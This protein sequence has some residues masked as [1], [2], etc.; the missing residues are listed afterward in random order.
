[1][2][3]TIVRTTFESVWGLPKRLNTTPENNKESQMFGRLQKGVILF[4][5]GPGR[6]RG[7]AYLVG[8][9]GPPWLGDPQRS[10]CFWQS[11]IATRGLDQSDSNNYLVLFAFTAKS[12]VL[13][14]RGESK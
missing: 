14:K 2:F 4:S 7:K 5:R 12:Q 10:T 9:P 8:R 3:S 6:N 1:M 11:L 13:E